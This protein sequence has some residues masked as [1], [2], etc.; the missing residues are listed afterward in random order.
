MTDAP[1]STAARLFDALTD[2]TIAGLYGAVARRIEPPTHRVP[3]A[4]TQPLPAL[5]PAG[6]MVEFVGAEG[7][8]ARTTTALAVV[9]QAQREG[10]PAAWIQAEGG[11]LFP[12]DVA[13]SGVDLDALVVVHVP[14]TAGAAGLARAAEL[15][16]RSNG[17]GVVV[18][19]L[20]GGVPPGDAWSGRLAGLARQHAL[21]LV[22]LTSEAAR[23]SGVG[24]LVGV[25]VRVARR[26][27]G[28]GSWALEADVLR[29]KG[30][31]PLDARPLARRSP[32]GAP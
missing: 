11:G 29:N 2:T 27:R 14:T 31:T 1:D 24:P 8:S 6:R 15:L 26:R 18:V 3:A 25:R 7:L 9:A 19:D 22:V 32:P 10:E 23:R 21:R 12:P 28:P 17:F 20:R 5:L 4:P 16:L 13:E 30:G